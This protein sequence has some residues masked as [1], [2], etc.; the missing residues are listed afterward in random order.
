MKCYKRVYTEVI[1]V[2]LCY[3]S[4]LIY[5]PAVAGAESDIKSVRVGIYEMQ[6]FHSFDKNGECTG[7]DVD[8]LNKI[9]E[10]TGWTYKYVQADSWSDAIGMLDSGKIDLLA[11]AQMSAERIHHYID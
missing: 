8:Y 4:A 1:A 10:S 3:L 11:P 6:G 7:Y 2:I 9:A 5:I